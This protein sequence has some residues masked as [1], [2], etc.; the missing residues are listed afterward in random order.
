[1]LSALSLYCKWQRR[2]KEI[3]ESG[4]ALFDFHLLSLSLLFLYFKPREYY[5]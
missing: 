1:M 3:A 2:R 4:L 5:S